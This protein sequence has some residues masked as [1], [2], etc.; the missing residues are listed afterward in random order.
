MRE[1]EIL[2]QIDEQCQADSKALQTKKEAI[3]LELV[4]LASAQ[5]F[6][7]QAVEHGSD[8]HILEVGNQVQTRVETLLTKQLDLES[9]FSEFQ[10]IENTANLQMKRRGVWEISYVPEVMGNHRLEIKVNSRDVTQSPFD[11]EVQERDTP[12]LAIGQEGNG[13]EELDRPI[14]VAVDKDGNIAVV[15]RGERRVQ[16]FT[17]TVLKDGRM[18]VADG[19][20]SPFAA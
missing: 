19:V 7:Q 13:V 18:V 3:E 14:D 20:V 9:N 5:T 1:K 8:V 10:F 2:S 4:G 6:C 15:D 17:D 11:V 12:V 16:V